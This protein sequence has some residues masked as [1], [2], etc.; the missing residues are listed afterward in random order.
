VKSSTL[1]AFLCLG[2]CVCGDAFA[3]EVSIKG[4]VSQTLDASNNYFMTK[5][6]SGITGHALSNI[7]LDFLAATPTTQY[8]LKTNYGY[9]KYFGPGA[10]DTPLTFG[11]TP[12]ATFTI[13]HVDALT[14]YNFIASWQ[15]S[16]VATTSLAETGNFAGRGTFDTYNVG[17]GFKR[18]LGAADTVSWSAQYSTV[19][20]SDPTSTPYVDYTSNAGW[21]HRLSATTTLVTTLNFDWLMVDNPADSQR[22]YWNPMAGVQSQL[23]KRLFFYGTAGFGFVNAYQ[24]GSATPTGTFQQN[25]G[26]TNGWLGNFNLNYQVFHD[27]NASL[28]ATRAISPTVT[29][30]LLDIESVALSLNHTINNRSSAS[31]FAQFSQTATAAT[32]GVNASTSDFFSASASYAYAIAREWRS[33]VSYTYSQRIDITGLVRSSAVSLTLTHDFTLFGKPPTEIQKTQSDIAQ[34]DLGRAQRAL[35]TVGVLPTYAQ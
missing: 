19:S 1:A 6:P 11:T 8:D 4:D 12:G 22:L 26:A 28:T 13:D 31:L 27:T 2:A 29:G 3:A 7:D 5:S 34:Q 18:D 21:N 15:R 25:V 14:K 20:F 9:Y 30:Q 17:G 24:N 16:D 35:P 33:S 32:P 10:Q 23:T